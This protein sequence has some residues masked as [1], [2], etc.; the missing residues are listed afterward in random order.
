[1]NAGSRHYIDKIIKIQLFWII[2]LFAITVTATNSIANE[3]GLKTG[4]VKWGAG[5]GVGKNRSPDS[6]D[7]EF[8][9][10]RLSAVFDR[11]PFFP[12]KPAKWLRWMLEAQAGSTLGDRNRFIA[13]AGMLVRAQTEPTQ[14]LTIYGLAGI[15]FIYTD[16]Q[17][18]GQGLKVNFNPQLG[19]GADFY[20]KYYFQVRLHH[21][22][23][24]NLHDDNTG[25]NNIVLHAG[26][27]F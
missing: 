11:D 22:S 14:W 25:I 9:T 15:G 26:I 6:D 4:P 5:F 16:F 18:E 19:I 13:S 20:E 17:V 24:A 23:N 1:M 21:I 27:Y 12:Y 8:L 10:A 3:I 7:I 2:V